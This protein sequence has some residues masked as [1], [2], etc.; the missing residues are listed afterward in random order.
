MKAHTH[1]K[2]RGTKYLELAI[3]ASATSIISGDKDLLVLNP[4][5]GIDVLSPGAFLNVIT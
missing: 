5:R 4:W 1:P 3:A 2:Q